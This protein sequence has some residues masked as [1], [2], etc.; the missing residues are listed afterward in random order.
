MLGYDVVEHGKPLQARLRETPVP[1][2]REAVLRV[3]HAGLCHSDIHLWKGYY[4]L[5]GGKRASLSDRGLFPPFTLGHESLGIVV[6]V[7]ED[8]SDVTVGERRLVFPW[9]A[10]GAC[11]ACDRGRTDLCAKQRTIGLATP[12][13][14]ATHILVPDA[15]YLVDVEGIDD[16]FAA[17]LACSGVS[18]YA[19]VN[20]LPALEATDYVAVIGCG[21]VGLTA[22]S[23]LRARG[24]ER[25]IACDVADDKLKAASAQGAMLT[26]RTDRDHAAQAL[27]ELA[28]GMV[29]GVLDFVGIPSTLQLAYGALRKGGT[30]VLCGLHGGEAAIALPPMV[31]RSLSL[32][33]SFVGTLAEL[34][35]TV[36]LAKARKLAALPIRTCAADQINNA[37]TDLDEGHVVGRTVLDFT[38]VAA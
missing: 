10:C 32:V 4:D 21:G 36:A 28:Q 3:T 7:G 20:K 27:S 1:K 14:F 5:G 15:R 24:I 30:Y 16:A 12:G 13:G 37:L 34:E 17:T 38:G 29:G 2:G 35:E 19:A 9:L 33:G 31:Q 22:I 18:S 26:L 23:I 6:A 25:I 8:V 11:W